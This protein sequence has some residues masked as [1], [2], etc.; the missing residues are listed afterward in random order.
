[1]S[2]EGGDYLTYS[3]PIFVSFLSF[4]L[5]FYWYFLFPMLGCLSGVVVCIAKKKSMLFYFLRVASL[6]YGESNSEDLL[7]G[8]LLSLHYRME[9]ISASAVHEV[10]RSWLCVITHSP[11]VWA[12]VR[13]IDAVAK[14]PLRD[15]SSIPPL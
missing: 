9:G 10:P 7:I 11:R 4:G 5:A 14:Q 6:Q 1:M 12:L 3:L 15:Q 13:L 8:V 2:W